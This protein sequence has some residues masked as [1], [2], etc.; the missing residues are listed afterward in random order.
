MRRRL[1]LALA[2]GFP[3]AMYLWTLSGAGYWLDGGEFVAMAVRLDIAHPPGHP[4]TG[5]YGKTLTLLPLGPLAFRVALGQALAAALG[6]VLLFRAGES[7][8]RAFGLRS[9]AL[10]TPIALLGAWL[11]AFGYAVWFQAIRPEVYALQDLSSF[12]AMERMARFVEDGGRDRRPLY[13]AALAVGLGLCNHHVMAFFMFPALIGCAGLALRRA[14]PRPVL[15]CAALGLLALSTYAYLPV[16]AA[17][18]PP[19]NLGDP[20]TFARM[21]WVVSAKVYTRYVGE[22]SPQPLSER[23]ADAG[24]VLVDDMQGVFALVALWGLYAA[25]RRRQSR[26]LGLLWLACAASVF[27]VRPWLGAV[28]GNPDAIAYMTSGIAAV[29]LLASAGVSA[30]ASFA[31]QSEPWSRK[32]VAPLWLVLAGA[33]A[34]AFGRGLPRVDL[35]GFHATDLFDEYRERGL[36]ARTAVVATTPQTVFRHFEIAATEQVRPDL[37]LL[38]LPFLGYPGVAEAVVRRH[39]DLRGLVDAFARSQQVDPAALSRLATRRPVLIELDSHVPP[40][41]YASLLPMGLLYASVQA[42]TARAMLAPAA[43]LQRR[44]YLRIYRDLGAGISEVETARQL[45]WGHYMDA[46]F[47]AARGALPQARSALALAARLRPED[48]QVRALQAALADPAL[49]GPLDVRPFLAFDAGSAEGATA[50]R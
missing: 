44:V 11:C 46:L 1:V 31:T 26:P 27:G 24:V 33:L 14:G 10:V 25:L 9:A 50:P 32:L 34:L 6:A 18:H 48:A 13:A 37:E 20:E 22:R 17:R 15:I 29:A 45:L 5:L 30:L 39:P 40:A 3:L 12:F 38:P 36:P 28:R 49:Q 41:A 42:S 7:T 47:Y 43:A 4:L 21:A 19:A 8:A 35:S 2:A 23:Y 16:R